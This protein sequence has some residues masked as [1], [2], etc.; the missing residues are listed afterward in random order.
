MSRVRS[1]RRLAE[2]DR[3]SFASFERSVRRLGWKFASAR[4]ETG[5]P[6]VKDTLVHVLNVR[7]AWLVAAAGKRWEVFDAPGRRPAEIGS[8]AQ[9]AAYR[10]RVWEPVDVLLDRLTERGLD[11]RV[12][13][14]WMPGRYT[15]EDAFFQ[16]SFEQ[17]HHL[18]EV[19]AIYWQEDR[20]PPQMMWVPLLTRSRVSV[21]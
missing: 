3:R 1:V 6:S 16:A 15:L 21:R 10:H 9:L 2:F 4:R 19:I 8:F 17:A 13:V 14:P 7:E 12:R 11:G 18:G 20:T 5:H